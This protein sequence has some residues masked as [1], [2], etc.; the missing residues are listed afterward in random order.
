MKTD[1]NNEQEVKKVNLF[2]NFIVLMKGYPKEMQDKLEE[3][4]TKV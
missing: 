3:H 2:L 1:H 4:M